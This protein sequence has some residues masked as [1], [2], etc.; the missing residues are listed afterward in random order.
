MS[1]RCPDCGAVNEDS[2]I[3]CASCG[4]PL[5]AELRLMRDLENMKKAPPPPKE[6]KP[7]PKE[8]PAP[9]KKKSDDDDDFTYKKMAKEK[10]SN[11]V[12]LIILGVAVVAA[13]IAFLVLS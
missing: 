2:K 3:Y 12:P 10:K 8:K 1:K 6:E 13:I 11:P 7:A 9:H 4:E 5:D